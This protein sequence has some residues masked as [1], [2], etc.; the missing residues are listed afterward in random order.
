MFLE[1]PKINLKKKVIVLE[2]RTTFSFHLLFLQYKGF[3]KNSKGLY[4]LS[5]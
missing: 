2:K 4:Q 1:N 3:E 5:I